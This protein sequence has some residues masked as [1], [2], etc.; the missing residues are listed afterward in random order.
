M[1]T[2]FSEFINI[3]FDRIKFIPDIFDNAFT[4][5]EKKCMATAFAVCLR[6]IKWINLK[7]QK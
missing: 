5:G 6:A 3:S 4:L 7:K 1:Y 2:A